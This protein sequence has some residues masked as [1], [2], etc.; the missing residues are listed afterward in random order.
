LAQRLL[1]A[2]SGR[3][4]YNGDRPLQT[5][6]GRSACRRELVNGARER[7]ESPTH[8]GANPSNNADGGSACQLIREKR[9]PADG[10]KAKVGELSAGVAITVSAAAT[11]YSKARRKKKSA[12]G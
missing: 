12:G 9:S 11:L 3:S 6:C 8:E 10:A 1:S 5:G 2:T 7:D 4:G